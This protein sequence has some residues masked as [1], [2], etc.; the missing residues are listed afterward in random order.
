MQKEEV[1]KVI[2][3]FWEMKELG[4]MEQRLSKMSVAAWRQERWTGA[5]M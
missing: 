4:V 5:R 2:T 1:A 3:L